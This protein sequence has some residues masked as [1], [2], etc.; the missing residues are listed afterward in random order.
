MAKNKLNDKVKKNLLDLQ[1][2]KYLQGYNT[3]IIIL[4]TYTI[5]V[6]IAFITK[7]IDYKNANQ[8][9]LIGLISVA[10]ISIIFIFMFR[11]REHLKNI[12]NEI[13]KLRL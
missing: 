13:K 3:S 12:P 1:Y 10:V 5:G 9:G 11:M 8:V 7:Q 6:I 4:F 2:N